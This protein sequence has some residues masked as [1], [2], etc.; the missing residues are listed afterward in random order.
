MNAACF[1]GSYAEARQRFVLAARALDA[2]LHT[3]PIHCGS[4]EDLAIDVAI[5]DAGATAGD[6]P[7]LVISSGLHGVE[8]FFGSAV[9]LALLQQLRAAGARAPLRRVLIH[10]LN[11]C[12]FARLRRVNEDNVDLNR[13]F[14]AGDESYAG[15]PAAYAKLDAL[16]NPRAAPSHSALF[17]L[18]ALWHIARD[19]LQPLKDAVAGGQYA[20]PQGLFYGGNAPSATTRIVQAHCDA[21]LG[22]SQSILHIDL[23]TGLGRYA[24]PSLLLGAVAGSESH[25]WCAD[26][27][28]TRNV[29]ASAQPHGTAYRTAGALGPWLQ[30]Q[31]AARRCRFITA[32][33]GT[34]GVLR[35]LAALRAENHAHHYCRSDDPAFTRAKRALLE[36]FCPASVQW[37]D[38]AIH[39]ALRII[40]Q[41]ARA[42]VR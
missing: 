21:W 36:C 17:R 30:Q 14:L 2:E 42:L 31:F 9:Q 32:E 26:V 29:E 4:D 27:Y 12:G 8:G 35:V 16:L 40:E 15:A 41:G 6:V 1:S 19:G 33:F 38:T 20:Y 7:T 18:Q 22:A 34:H 24:R 28:G 23:H 13:N 25:A 10:A 3:H 5:L 11:P 39:A 37:R